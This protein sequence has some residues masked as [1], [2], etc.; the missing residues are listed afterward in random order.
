MEIL[1]EI[2]LILALFSVSNCF[3]A[4]KDE[5]Q[6]N[7]TCT[8]TSIT[9][10]SSQFS[11]LHCEDITLIELSNSYLTENHINYENVTLV[12]CPIT[13]YVNLQLHQFHFAKHLK[14]SKSNITDDKIETFLMQYGNNFRN[15][16]S[17]DLSYNALDC[18]K[19]IHPHFIQ[20]LNI[21]KLTA[22]EIETDSCNFTH[23]CQLSNLQ[24]LHLD[25]NLMNTLN[26]TLLTNF[27]DL[28]IL[29][30]SS[31]NISDI[32]R[33]T[34]NFTINLRQLLISRNNVSILPFQLF[35]TM[36]HLNVLDLS[37]NRILSLPDN[38]FAL[39]IALKELLLKHNLLQSIERN[40]FFGLK[41]INTLD[42]S[43]NSIAYIDKRAFY[44]LGSLTKLNL[45]HNKL[46][47]IP[48]SLFHP[49]QNIVKLDISENGFTQLPSGL[50]KYQK[51]L[52][53]LSIDG[54][55]L[56]K[57]GNWISNF[58]NE[59]NSRILNNLN[60][61]S[62]QYNT[63]L[64]I[65]PKIIFKNAVNI[66]E[67]YLSNNALV[68]IASEVGDLKNL[69][70]L[71]LKN[72]RLTYIP[73]S[74]R[75]LEHIE[76]ISLINNDYT[77][78]CKMYWLSD[79]LTKTVLNINQSSEQCFDCNSEYDMNTIISHLKCHQG[80]PGDMIPVLKNLHCFKPSI[81]ESFDNRMHMLYSTVNLECSFSGSP[82]PDIVW[83]TPTN[84]LL[85]HRAD[86]EKEP[87]TLKYNGIRQ[88][89]YEFEDENSLNK[90]IQHRYIYSHY[91]LYEN[92]SLRIFNLSRSDSGIYTC[93]AFNLMGS[94]SASIRLY[95]DPNIFYK[96][97]IESIMFGTAAA[98][99]FLLLT[100]FIQGIRMLLAKYGLYYKTCNVF[101]CIGRKKSPRA[102]QIYAMLDSI[103]HYKNQQLE[104]LRENYAQQLRYKK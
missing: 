17:L 92:G 68:H 85:R 100:L 91:A 37:Y 83:V 21:L 76:F 30:V 97:K 64:Q 61:L 12:H 23:L 79:W 74:I 32:P 49:L 31:N 99:L 35:K 60:V 36:Q 86:P 47:I 58:D 84:H 80:Y 102:K 29:N 20:K 71:N 22:N 95:I 82:I 94:T 19:W 77:C 15:L 8:F 89:T 5:Q 26:N 24:E 103:E 34:F 7:S 48:A 38:F 25:Q 14:W 96:L 44:S 72:N 88:K 51:S 10:T 67:L 56:E 62:M 73:E 93:Y 81:L 18:V 13:N 70:L 1:S 6:R 53:T 101:V 4:R 54:T 27:K 52:N 50:F 42:L 3:E 87:M 104:R 9:E 78:D 2:T 75:K 45:R 39:N 40:V 16:I 28:K 11:Q 65:I 98:T 55:N 66:T 69:K 33:N 63:K 90:T 59:V 41:E 43:Y 46:R 57:L